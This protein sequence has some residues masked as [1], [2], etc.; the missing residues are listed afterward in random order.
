MP[1]PRPFH[2]IVEIDRDGF[3]TKLREIEVWLADWQIDAEIGSV[4]GDNGQLRIRFADERAAY[5]FQRCH[6]GRLL[7]ADEID[8]AKLAD[9]ADEDLYERL[10][11]E[12]PD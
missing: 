12:Y 8:A 10:A 7:P 9:A 5:A 3:H 1:E 11:C 2:I 4:L 6:G